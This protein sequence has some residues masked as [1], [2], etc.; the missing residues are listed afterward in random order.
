MPD[1]NPWWWL[2]IAGA[3]LVGFVAW[4]EYANDQ[5]DTGWTDPHQ[6]PTMLAPV[7]CRPRGGRINRATP[8]ARDYPDTLSA[9]PDCVV[10]D[11]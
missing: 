6:P 3:V 4:H 10:G 11:I 1:M 5:G 2:A 7:V 9:W 8:Y